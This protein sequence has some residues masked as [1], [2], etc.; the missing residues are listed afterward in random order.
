MDF[1][2]DVLQNLL[3]SDL[4]DLSAEPASN[5]KAAKEALAASFFKKWVPSNTSTLEETAVAG[6]QAAN[7]RCRDFVIDRNSEDFA[8]YCTMKRML[9]DVF[10][11]GPL[12]TCVLTLDSSL[13]GGRAGPGSSRST[14]HTDFFHKMFFG[15]LS[16]TSTMLYYHYKHGIS[17]RWQNAELL[18]AKLY[19]V[20]VVEGSSLSTVPK[21]AKTN[22]TICT[23]PSLN[24]F[25]QLGAGL[26]IEGLLKKF[27]N[28]DLS[29]QPDIN[30]DLAQRGSISGEFSTIDL[31]SASDTISMPLVT[32]LLPQHVMGTLRLLRSPIT[33]YKGV[34]TELSMIS[35]MGNG[36][37]FPLQTII[38]ATLVRAVYL[39]LGI[40]PKSKEDR[41]YGVFGDD[42]ICVEEAYDTVCR[43]LHYCGFIVNSE[44]S[45]NEGPFRESCGGDF[46]NGYDIRGV[47]VKGINNEQD[48]FSAFNRLARWS[49]KHNIDLSSVLRYLKGLVEFRPVPYDAGDTEGIKCPTSH[50]ATSFIKTDRNGNRYY[51]ATINV[52]LNVKIRGA[53]LEYNPDAVIISVIGGYIRERR[54][55]L[56]IKQPVCKVVKRKTPRWDF[57]SDAGLT[58][59]D[60]QLIW[61]YIS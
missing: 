58:I 44:K 29:L 45:Y 59:R 33:S 47:Y 51:S 23:E 15:R 28:I 19:Q 25:Y 21:N 60:Y 55:G 49:A 42:I 40:T 9:Y 27:H 6:F 54:I 37:T 10:Y 13:S 50:L 35:S 32:D 1:N 41:N 5:R 52:G 24:M 16:T 39:H 17:P 53:E 61:E 38:F 22:R 56:R 43:M 31:S 14:N 20:D 12:Q 34:D 2:P 7:A 46:W 4:G 11:S 57:V 3:M 30:K 26:V 48:V 36:F 8:I 18:R